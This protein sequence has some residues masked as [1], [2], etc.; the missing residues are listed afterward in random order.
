MSHSPLISIC[1]PT[2]N[3]AALLRNA[4]ESIAAEP[5]F[6]DG[7]DIEVTISDNVSTDETPEVAAEFVKR[8]P[9][10]VIYFRQPEAVDPH[11]NFKNSLDIATGRWLKLQNDRAVFE[12]GKLAALLE[13]HR[14]AESIDAG[15]CFANEA[16]PPPGSDGFH[17]FHKPEELL[18]HVS[19]V[20][21]NI[22]LYS[23]RSDL[24]RAVPDPFRRYQL[25]FPHIDLTFRLMLAGHSAAVSDGK[26]YIFQLNKYHNRNE[27]AIFDGGYLKLLEEYLAIGAITRESY[28]FEKKNALLMQIIPLY[29]DFHGKFN[30]APCPGFRVFWRSTPRYHREWYYY[31]IIPCVYIYRGLC[32]LPIPDSVH[33]LIREI[34]LFLHRGS[35][36][37]AQIRQRE[38]DE[39][40][41]KKN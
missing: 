1:I 10:K 22:A 24:Y 25:Y 39:K 18:H 28:R 40:K 32:S 2:Y 41:A 13:F 27:A 38:M 16:F 31:L 37:V 19:V 21:A 9:G 12:P 23:F 20:L 15:V 26:Y 35:P 14:R 4:L 29:F 36:E 5:V 11:F 33:R 17:C 3:R 8:F 30:D 6:R 7:N 34:Y